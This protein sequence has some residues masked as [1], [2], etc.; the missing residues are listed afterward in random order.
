MAPQRTARPG[1]DTD[2]DLKLEPGVATGV[3]GSGTGC[4]LILQ[5]A[6]RKQLTFRL[7]RF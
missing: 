3:E 6:P 2:I 7:I 4:A 1:I 5:G